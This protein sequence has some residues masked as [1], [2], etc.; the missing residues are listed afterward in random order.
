MTHV[1]VTDFS[2]WRKEARHYLQAGVPPEK[3]QWSSEEKQQNLFKLS[4][5]QP[6]SHTNKNS[7][8]TVPPKFIS[9][10]QLV[11]CHKDQKKWFLLYML[12]WRITHGEKR[13][14]HDPADPLVLLLERMKK[15]VSFDRHKMTAFVRFR[16]SSDGT[17]IAWHKPE[18]HVTDL[19]LSFFQKRFNSMKWAILTPNVS[20]YWDTERC[21]R[22]E[23]VARDPFFESDSVENL[24]KEYYRAI[25]NPARIKTKMMKREMP[26]RY[27]DSLPETSLIPFMLKEAPARLNAMRLRIKEAA[28]VPS[29]SCLKELKTAAL[30]CRACSLC[31]SA[32]QTVFGEGSPSAKILFIGE[33]PEETEISQAEPLADQ[34]DR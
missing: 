2:S 31:L 23:G 25:F 14:L 21:I 9:L 17:F 33:Q 32:T 3:I 30:T 18:H 13:L 11:S 22:G 34:Q 29:V 27:W 28:P 4:T 5:H 24:W 1:Y 7:L 26:V 16:E 6:L 12:L 19:A 8:L 20:Y 10:A 15:E